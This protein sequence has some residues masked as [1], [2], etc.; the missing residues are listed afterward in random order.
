MFYP[1]STDRI[2]MKILQKNHL[3]TRKSP[4]TFGNHPDLD[5]DLGIFKENFTTVDRENSV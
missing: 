2:F 4:L 3:W 1:A 5:L